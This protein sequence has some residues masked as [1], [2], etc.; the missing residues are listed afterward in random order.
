LA[1]LS[2]AH[3]LVWNDTGDGSIVDGGAVQVDGAGIAHLAI[4]LHA[5]FVLTT[6]P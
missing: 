4:P 5:A 3:L 2:S 1:P 6:L